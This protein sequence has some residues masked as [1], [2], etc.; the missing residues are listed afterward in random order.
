MMTTESLLAATLLTP[1]GEEIAAEA[2]AVGVAVTVTVER[3]TVT[4]T[5]T[6]D[7]LA[8]PL[9]AAPEPEAAGEPADPPAPVFPELAPPE[10]DAEALMTVT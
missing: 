9:L 7:P 6:Q 8:A 2:A 5:G 3:A 4:V 1:A 10:A